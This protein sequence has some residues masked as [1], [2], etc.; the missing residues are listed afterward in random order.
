MKILLGLIMALAPSAAEG[1]SWPNFR[2]DEARAAFLNEGVAPPLTLR[3]THSAGAAVLSSPV[4][5]YDKVYFGSRDNKVYCLDAYSGTV[6]W[7][8]STGGWVDATPA[9]ADGKVFSPSRDGRIY[10]LNALTGAV[11]WSFNPGSTN[12][13][14]PVVLTGEVYFA[15]GYPE[16][17][18]YVLDAET[19]TVNRSTTVPNVTAS[20]PV[21]DKANSRIFLGGGGGRYNA[22]NLDLTQAW[23][24]P[25]QTQGSIYFATPALS[26]G[27]LLAAPGDDDKTLHAYTSASGSENWASLNLVRTAS[28]LSLSGGV[29][30]STNLA[31]VGAAVNP[32]TLFAIG[33]TTGGVAWTLPLG[34]ASNQGVASSPA[35]ANNMLFVLSP[36]GELYAVHTGTGEVRAQ[37]ALDGEGLSSPAVANGWVYAA[38]M[39]GKVYG[40]ESQRTWSLASPDILLDGTNVVEGTVTVVGTVLSPTLQ[41]FSLQ[42]GQGAN[43]ATWTTLASSTFGVTRS[44]MAVWNTNDLPVSE[45]DNTY[46]LRLSVAETGATDLI[47][48][49]RY[50]VSVPQLRTLAVN[51]ASNATL[52][53]ADGTEIEI[54][55]GALS[56]NDTLTIKKLFSPYANENVGL[57]DGAQAL[58]VAREFTLASSANPTFHKDVTIK[59]PY[60]NAQYTDEDALRMYFFD[61]TQKIWRILNTSRVNKSEKRVVAGV[62]HFT[63]FRLMQFGALAALLQDAEV[64]SYPNPARGDAVTFKFRLGDTADV[65]IRVYDIAGDLVAELSKFGAPGGIA[66]TLTWDVS[67]KASGVYIYRLEAK[68][69]AGETAHVTKKLA[70]IH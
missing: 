4:V 9:V 55:A 39:N 24:Q 13:S 62:K 25:V 60:Q 5:A 41:S 33:L 19:G 12:L 65:T 56:G 58:G 64:Y 28:E 8:Y 46:T 10:A 6:L 17:R 36:Q 22:W 37:I 18:L 59:M 63:K 3:W 20:S 11:M 54:P 66:S 53:L 7:S 1:L 21:I 48:E 15:A 16:K 32:H 49:A 44:S 34:A 31:F 38:T 69:T 61:E 30:V 27:T 43:P 52:S 47:T 50:Q 2:G 14:S 35:V 51:A 57:P 40:F 29:A 68:T 23:A 26:S 42:Y 67:G 45:S 70:I